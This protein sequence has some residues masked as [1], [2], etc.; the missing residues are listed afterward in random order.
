MI[1]ETRQ[2]DNVMNRPPLKRA[3]APHWLAGL[4][5]TA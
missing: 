4:R 2:N 5:P 1:I 3:R